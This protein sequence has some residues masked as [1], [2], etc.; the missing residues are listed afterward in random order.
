M[1]PNSN[2]AITNFLARELPPTLEASPEIRQACIHEKLAEFKEAAGRRY[3]FPNIAG[4]R[5]QALITVSQS[6]TFRAASSRELRNCS[7]GRVPSKKR[8]G[9]LKSLRVYP[10]GL[11][12]PS[13]VLGIALRR[14]RILTPPWISTMKERLF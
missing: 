6:V 8:K 5:N 4:G 13:K 1:D 11:Q 10:K 12:V 9:S 14:P 3:R 2:T 7:T